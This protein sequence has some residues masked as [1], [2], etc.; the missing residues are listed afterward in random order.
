M[1]MIDTAQSPEGF[2]EYKAHNPE[3]FPD[4]IPD[5]KQQEI[6]PVALEIQQKDKMGAIASGSVNVPSPHREWKITINA[7]RMQD[8]TSLALDALADVNTPPFLFHRSRGLVR[9]NYDEKGMPLIEPLTEAALRGIIERC[10]QFQKMNAKGEEKPIS[11]PLDV[12]RDIATLPEWNTIYPLAG[13]IECPTISINNVLTV[14]QGYN[15]NTRLYYAPTPGFTS[16]VVR[17]RPTKEDIEGSVKLLREI[18]INFPFVDEASRTNTIATLM[19]AVIRPMINGLVPMALFNK[20][21]AGVGASMI[22]KTIALVATGRPATMITAPD[23]DEEWRKKITATLQN[24]RTIAIVDNIENKL[25]APSLAALLTM[26]NWGDRLLG[27]SKDISLPNRVQWIGN[28]NNILLGGDL[29]RRCYM[30]NLLADSARP[31]QRDESKFIHPHLL[32]WVLTNRTRIIES[33]LTIARAWILAGKPEPGESVPRIGGFEEWRS[34]VGGIVVNAGLPDFLGNLEEMYQQSDADTLQWGLFFER[35]HEKYGESSTTVA[36]IIKGMKKSED[37]AQTKFSS[38]D[39]RYSEQI[40]DPSDSIS[41]IEV[42]PDSLLDSWNGKKS[43]SR[44]FGN[45]LGKKKDVIFVNGLQLKKGSQE[46]KVATWEVRKYE[47]GG[48]VK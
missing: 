12:I 36:E 26:E 23:S 37:T 44:V 10:C 4:N 24:G 13:I 15:S 8:Q 43:F 40:I 46:H 9:I 28:G 5:E 31:W 3:F 11:P 48:L 35:W 33:I 2:K 30:I 34:I 18:Y 17:D 14:E 42:L 47:T 1:A 6:Y 27:L 16:P 39:P 45:K 32:E 22:A 41:L 38:A 7:M 20:P 29:P 25:Y 19:S 21:Q